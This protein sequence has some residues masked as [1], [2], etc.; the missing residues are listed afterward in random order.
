LK[1]YNL[2]IQH[3]LHGSLF[4]SVAKYYYK[5]WE[6]PSIK[7]DPDGKGKEMLQ[8]IVYHVVLAPHDNEQSDMLHRLYIDP[9]L[10]KLELH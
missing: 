2:M 8:N 5:I 7:S 6:T 4:L 3:A 9:A 10:P 1:Y